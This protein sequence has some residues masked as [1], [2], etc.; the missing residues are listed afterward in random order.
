MVAIIYH[1]TNNATSFMELNPAHSKVDTRSF[2]RTTYNRN[3]KSY[4]TFY[5]LTELFLFINRKIIS[6]LVWFC[7]IAT[8]AI[9]FDLYISRTLKILKHVRYMKLN[10]KLN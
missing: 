1:G 5:K 6:S 2:G 9:T 7:Y 10:G 8:I 3:L 4:S